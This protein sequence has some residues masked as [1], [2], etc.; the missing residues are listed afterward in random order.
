MTLLE[1]SKLTGISENQAQDI[2]IKYCGEKVLSSKL[3]LPERINNKISELIDNPEQI[4]K[5]L[6]DEYDGNNQSVKVFSELIKDKYIIIIDTCIILSQHFESLIKAVKPVLKEKNQ[7]IIL[8]H[9]VYLEMEY[10]S[11]G[12][13]I[14][15]KRNAQ[16][17]ISILKDLIS[18]N[19][20]EE[21]GSDDDWTDKSKKP[22]ADPVI[23]SQTQLL[24]ST[25]K[26][27]AVITEDKKLSEDLFN[28]NKLKSVRSK[29]KIKVCCLDDETGNLYIKTE[30]VRGK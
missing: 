14:R 20:M 6:N 21:S 30:N 10:H 22:F 19:I 17:K 18:Q 27:S 26:N 4:Q 8:P 13:D 23:I 16:K 15:L 5:I 12:N 24:R 29:A 25:G 1:F 11:K 7:K 3:Q 2:I 9:I 28:N